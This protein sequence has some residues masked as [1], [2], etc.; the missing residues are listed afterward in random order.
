VGITGLGAS[1]EVLAANAFFRR[2]EAREPAFLTAAS[3]DLGTTAASCEVGS[4]TTRASVT[5]AVEGNFFGSSLLL[6]K[7]AK[8][9]A[10]YPSRPKEEHMQKSAKNSRV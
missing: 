6:E 5:G 3:S 8:G 10:L 9:K 7:E 4:S 1:R 2:L